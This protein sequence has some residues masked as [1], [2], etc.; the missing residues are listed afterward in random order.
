MPGLGNFEVRRNCT[1][2]KLNLMESLE[3]SMIGEH[4]VEWS[5]SSTMKKLSSDEIA[6][7]A[8][9]YLK[10]RSPSKKL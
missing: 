3:R 5:G 9:D 8:W 4:L 10:N 6:H 1:I 2:S 7:S